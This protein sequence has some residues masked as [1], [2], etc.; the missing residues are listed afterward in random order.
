[1]A[2]IKDSKNTEDNKEVK[3]KEIIY[4]KNFIKSLRIV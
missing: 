2:T 3:N 1:V 4:D